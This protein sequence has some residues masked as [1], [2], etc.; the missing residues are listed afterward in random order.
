MSVQVTGEAEL[1]R[2]LL[3]LG[4]DME[5]ALRAGVFLTAQQIRT[6]AIKSIQ[7]QAPGAWLFKNP[8]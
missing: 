8:K 3:S 2:I 5:D 4:K 6:H 1:K 7:E